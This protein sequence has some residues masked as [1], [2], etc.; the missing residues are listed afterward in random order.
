MKFKV[1]RLLAI[2]VVLHI[3]SAAHAYT[4]LLTRLTDLGE[5]VEVGGK[6]YLNVL[7]TGDSKPGNEWGWS[8]DVVY[9][10]KVHSGNN[11]WFEPSSANG[12][13]VGAWAGFKVLEP[14]SVTKIRYYARNDGSEY[15]RRAIGVKFQAATDAEFSDAVDLWTIP[16][17]N[18]DDLTN[19]WQEVSLVPTAAKYTCFRI[20][21]DYGGNLCEAEFY[22]TTD[23]LS[24]QSAPVAPAFEKFA[25][26]NGRLTYGWTAAA[27]ALIYRVERRYAG[28]EAWEVLARHEYVDEGAVISAMVDCYLPGPAE[29]RVVAV[30]TA[31]ETASEAVSVAYFKS[32]KGEAIC[33]AAS[34]S[35]AKSAAFDG[36]LS[37]YYESN[38]TGGHGEGAYVGYSLNKTTQISGV[39]LVP[40]E[41]QEWRTKYAVVQ[42]ADNAEFADAVD[43]LSLGWESF[44][45]KYVTQVVAGD[46][47]AGNMYSEFT[48]GG[49]LYVRYCQANTS[50]EDLFCNIAEVEFIAADPTPDAAPDGFTINADAHFP[51]LTWELPAAACMTCRVTRS[52]APGGGTDTVVT[53]LRGDTSSWIDESAMA[54]VTYYYSLS[55]VNNVDG[56]EYA[57]ESSEQ[58]AYRLISQIERDEAD[59]T[60]LRDGM[61]PYDSDGNGTAAMF[62]G[63]VS[64]GSWP[65]LSEDVKVGVDL[66]GEYVVEKFCVYPRNDDYGLSR[67]NGMVLATDGGEVSDVCV[68]STDEGSAQWYEFATTNKC[69][70]SRFY[71]MRNDGNEFHG[72][73]AELRLYG[74]KKSNVADVLLAPAELKVEWDKWR[75]ALDWEDCANAT[76]YSVERSVDGGAWQV[77]ASGLVASEWCDETASYAKHAYTYRIV[78]NGANDAFAVSAA[79]A[80]EGTGSPHGLRVIIR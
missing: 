4:G 50:G 77:V 11:A 39:R 42:V 51:T 36:D 48:T 49:G 40:R 46:E 19:K 69:A 57:G 54:G 61:R 16:E 10:G 64:W 14:A 33:D 9:D 17:M 53:D 37:T 62:D 15:A 31:G 76:S 68:I 58:V 26:V 3:S 67:C 28:E 43:L 6:S 59:Q 35:E 38:G 32:V 23:S 52:T 45:S 71:L 56:V 29:Y 25:L 24:A 5:K 65:D 72:N 8:K 20:I 41:G 78:S 66:D 55:F 1:L 34:E 80:P 21:G 74:Y 30:N 63:S 2:L 27:D 47:P 18:L 60:K 12:E 79:M 44:S 70:A 73:V 7:G 75:V 22:G 13:P